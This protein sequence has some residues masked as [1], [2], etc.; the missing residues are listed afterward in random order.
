MFLSKWRSYTTSICK[1]LLS[2]S[3]T[4]AGAFLNY[5]FILH[6]FVYLARRLQRSANQDPH[7]I[8]LSFFWQLFDFF[9]V[10]RGEFRQSLLPEVLT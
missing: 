5:S 6:L 3:K 1:R 4:S 2:C 7:F 10:N 9:E 8:D